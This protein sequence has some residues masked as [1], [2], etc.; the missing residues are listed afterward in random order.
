MKEVWQPLFE[1]MKTMKVSA[2]TAGLQL[3]LETQGTVCAEKL[4][5]Q[6]F[7]IHVRS[8][9]RRHQFYGGVIIS[10]VEWNS[11]MA[12]EMIDWLALLPSATLNR[13]LPKLHAEET[14]TSSLSPPRGVIGEQY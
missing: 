6:I 3:F 14:L 7:T 5:L 12:C 2:Y 8:E 11:L 13:H 10:L 4:E 1:T 9:H